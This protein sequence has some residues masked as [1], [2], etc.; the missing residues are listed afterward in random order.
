LNTDKNNLRLAVL[1][2]ADNIDTSSCDQLFTEVRKLGEPSIKRIYGDWAKHKEWKE[3]VQLLGL[4]PIQQFAHTKT[5]N[6]VDIA[7]VVDAMDLLHTANVDGFCIVASDSDYTRLII[8]IRES[9][10]AVY[11]F[12]QIKAI[13]SLKNAYTKFIL[14]GAQQNTINI[15]NN[16]PVSPDKFKNDPAVIN[17]IKSAIADCHSTDGWVFLSGLISKLKQDN[18]KPINEQHGYKHLSKFLKVFDVFEL[19]ETNQKVRLKP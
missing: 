12:G 7:L 9:G 1:I 16:K 4:Q 13:E 15:E 19:N 2:D 6:A 14:L 11:G 3:K 8:R 18:T 10:K 17:K 5:K